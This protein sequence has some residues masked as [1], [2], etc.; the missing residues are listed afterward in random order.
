MHL[1]PEREFLAGVGA[2]NHPSADCSVGEIE[3]EPAD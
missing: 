3:A 1:G 2:A